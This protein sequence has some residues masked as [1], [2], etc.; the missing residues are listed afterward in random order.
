[1]WNISKQK[2]LNAHYNVT[3]LS[4]YP[5]LILLFLDITQNSSKHLLGTEVWWPKVSNC[6]YAKHI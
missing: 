2:C 6:S 5:Q 1:M 4:I 3:K